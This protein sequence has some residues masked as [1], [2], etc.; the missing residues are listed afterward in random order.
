MKLNARERRRVAREAR[1]GGSKPNSVPFEAA[2]PRPQSIVTGEWG[3]LTR[4][5]GRVLL[6]SDDNDVEWEI[7]QRVIARVGDWFNVLIQEDGRWLDRQVVNLGGKICLCAEGRL[8][9]IPG[10]KHAVSSSMLLPRGAW[11]RSLD[12]VRQASRVGEQPGV[13][14]VLIS[15]G[16]VMPGAVLILDGRWMPSMRASDAAGRPDMELSPGGS[17]T[18]ASTTS[19]KLL[20]ESSRADEVTRRART[21]ESRRSRWEAEK[22]EQIAAELTDE[23]SELRRRPLRDGHLAFARWAL[24][25]EPQGGLPA[26]GAWLETAHRDELVR[27]LA[28]Y[29]PERP[30]WHLSAGLARTLAEHPA[31]ICLNCFVPPGDAVFLRIPGWETGPGREVGVHL[32]AQ[33]K[34][35]VMDCV[36]AEATDIAPY[37]R[38]SQSLVQSRVVS[39]PHGLAKRLLPVWQCVRQLLIAASR[40]PIVEG[41][42]NPKVPRA[43]DVGVSTS[44]A[45]IRRR[46]KLYRAQRL[47]EIDPL[48]LEL[49]QVH[50]ELREGGWR[51]S[52]AGITY[53]Q[54]AHV[55]GGTWVR[56][57]KAWREV[58]AENV[59]DGEPS[60]PAS[61]GKRLVRRVVRPH[62]RGGSPPP[63]KLRTG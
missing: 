5:Q 1:Q 14:H 23:R 49:K 39:P 27:L 38:L 13:C 30:T 31:E 33:E 21:E 48:V 58:R 9:N 52:R 61:D 4:P 18:A 56:R 60:F 32:F 36:F 8:P 42:G 43:R 40:E 51:W 7:G 28:R 22:I 29:G 44:V 24:G 53:V 50:F 25:E 19:K 55:R 10:I 20:H 17:A 47:I 62:T 37:F 2:T 45:A 11:E 46:G 59:C 15:S 54:G 12:L 35:N 6:A 3:Y 57:H 16:Q 63:A 26:T 41:L 34:L